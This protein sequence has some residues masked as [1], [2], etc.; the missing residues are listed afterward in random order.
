MS[1]PKI[2]WARIHEAPALATHA[3]LPG[4]RAFTNDAGVEIEEADI[5]RSGRILAAFPERL[6]E[7][8][9]IPDELS[10]TEEFEKNA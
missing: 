1:G 9:R 3:L 5:A 8:Q 2:T 7:D 4:V 6:S 10:P